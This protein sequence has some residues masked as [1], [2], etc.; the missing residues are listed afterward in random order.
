MTSTEHESEPLRPR[1]LTWAALLGRW[2]EFARSAVALPRDAVGNALRQSVPD[3]IMLQAVRFAL[4]DLDELPDDQRALGLDRAEILID[5]HVDALSRRWHATPPQAP[6]PA[7]LA[8]PG[9]AHADRHNT[10]LPSP[11]LDLIDEARTALADA[12]AQPPP[13]QTRPAQADRPADDRRAE[14]NK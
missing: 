12:Q 2:M 6:T 7:A 8:A 9:G 3:I 4:Q 10:P 14:D 1:H 13:Q 11:L 5:K